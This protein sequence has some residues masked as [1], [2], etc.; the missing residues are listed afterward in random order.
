MVEYAQQKHISVRHQKY[1]YAILKL[2]LSLS[3]S[4]QA[5]W[6]CLLYFKMRR[7]GVGLLLY[8]LQCPQ[9]EYPSAMSSS[10]LLSDDA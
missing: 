3:T 6:V 1:Q 10:L 4:F 2:L 8:G 9:E 7:C 5:A